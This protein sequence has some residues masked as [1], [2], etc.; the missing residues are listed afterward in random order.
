MT[1][2]MKLSLAWIAMYVVCTVFGF[3]LPANDLLL[4]VEIALALGFFVP[5]ALLLHYAIA[6]ERKKTVLILQNICLASLGLTLALLVLNFV[7]ILLPGD[8]GTALY[9]ILIFVSTPMICSQYW[10]LSLFC[11]AC[12]LMVC[13]REQRKWKKK[14]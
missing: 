13:L 9:F 5:P 3:I 1:K 14:K 4:V 10:L 12:L 2:Q 6:T 7:S 8:V 11:W